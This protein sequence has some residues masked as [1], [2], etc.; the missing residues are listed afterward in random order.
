M[1]A[2]ASPRAA[3]AAYDVF[4]GDADGLCALHQL[5][6]A[7]P[8]D[9]HCITGV[10]RDVSLLQRVPCAGGIDV[11]VLDV[12]L[13]A[14]VDA[15]ARLLDAGADV[16]YYDHHSARRAFLHPRLHLE[17]DDSPHVCTSMLVDRTL[18]GRFRPRSS[19]RRRCN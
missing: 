14:N 1:Q 12:S 8:R 5:R 19:R 6:L 9:A 11:T 7:C 10:K 16:D 2:D 13:D 4:N 17:W 15:L 18:G 3:R